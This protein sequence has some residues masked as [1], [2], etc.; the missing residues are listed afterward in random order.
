MFKNNYD[1]VEFGKR[2]K[3]VRKKNGMTQEQLADALYL[4][5]DSVSRIETG[6][7]MCMP[8]HLVHICEL[9]HVSSDYLYF[10]KMTIELNQSQKRNTS[11]VNMNAML[12]ECGEENL[13]RLEQMMKLF[14]GL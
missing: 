7:G 1:A 14:L 8:E 12:A 11:L 3:E 5:V 10:G 13:E 4:S 2:I 6:K 9:F